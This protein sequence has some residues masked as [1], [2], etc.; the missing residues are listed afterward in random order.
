MSVQP[1][2]Y[3]Q[4]LTHPATSNVPQSGARSNP[5]IKHGY[6][7]PHDGQLRLG[8]GLPS[9]GHQLATSTPPSSTLETAIE[10]AG[11]WLFFLLTVVL[12]G[13]AFQLFERILDINLH[14]PSY[15]LYIG[16][17]SALSWSLPILK[18]LHSVLPS[19][20]TGELKEAH[21]LWHHTRREWVFVFTPVLIISF[22]TLFSDGL[23]TAIIEGDKELGGDDTME[24]ML[25]GAKCAVGVCVAAG[26][27]LAGYHWRNARR[28]AEKGQALLADY[29]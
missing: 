23:A 1:P 18:F 25:L 19:F 27:A 24:A 14:I 3:L 13:I 12:F 29:S 21:T 26:V 20:F 10:R 6:H 15:A 11:F 17:L 2:V 22:Y 16:A 28:E 5:G 7:N 9:A 8:P 4:P